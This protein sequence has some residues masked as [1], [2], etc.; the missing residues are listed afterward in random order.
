MMT[1]LAPF[2]IQKMKYIVA[3]N[4]MEIV[5]TNIHGHRSQDDVERMFAHNRFDG[6]PTRVV[7]RKSNTFASNQANH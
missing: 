4:L 1:I 6:T 7:E 5:T 2:L 3:G